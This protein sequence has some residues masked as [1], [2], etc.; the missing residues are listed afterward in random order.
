M[1]PQVAQFVQV[2]SAYVRNYYKYILEELLLVQLYFKVHAGGKYIVRN[3]YNCIN[4]KLC[5]VMFVSLRKGMG[6]P[7]LRCFFYENLCR[8]GK[9]TQYSCIQYS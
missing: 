6:R 1:I 9:D 3:Y 2:V 8:N 4:S 7:I 5:S